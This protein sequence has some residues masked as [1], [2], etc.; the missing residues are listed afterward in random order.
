MYVKYKSITARRNTYFHDKRKKGKAH[1]C[2]EFYT[3]CG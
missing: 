3:V 2:K 1:S